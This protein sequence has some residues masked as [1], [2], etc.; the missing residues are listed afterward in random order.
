MASNK[1]SKKK[2]PLHDNILM[3]AASIPLLEDGSGTTATTGKK[4]NSVKNYLW[5]QYRS[6]VRKHHA[7]IDLAD[8]AV[9]RLLFWLPHHNH[10][11]E[12][13]SPPWREVLY[14]ILSV[15]QL[16]MYCSQQDQMENTYGFSLS[17]VDE[18]RISAISLR[19]VMHA[20]HSLMPSIL[21]VAASS[22]AGNLTPQDRRKRQAWARYR[23]EQFKF[24]ARLYLTYRYW[25]QIRQ[26]GEDSSKTRNMQPGIMLNGGIYQPMI[27]SVGLSQEEMLTIRLKRDY[28][29][30]R[31]GLSLS[32]PDGGTSFNDDSSTRL[33]SS[34]R[35][36]LGEFLYMLRPLVWAN[37][38][39]RYS[40]G[41][42]QGSLSRSN[43]APHRGRDSLS[44]AW[45]ITLVM[46]V[47]SLGFLSKER[48]S[49]NTV[50]K[51]EWFR[52]RTKLM[53]YLLRAP[54]WTKATCPALEKTSDIAS[55]IPLLGRIF[56]SYLWDWVLYWKHPFV[57]EEG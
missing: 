9:H 38:E 24:A 21:E 51:E 45:L 17:T 22:S 49:G 28:R 39:A 15:N 8:D 4:P 33:S 43:Q 54:M 23:L 52:R 19:I 34:I 55:H 42:G 53:L 13:M 56:E 50:S 1:S 2:K 30:R 18:P 14:G 10:S 46:D 41:G 29:G 48:D 36:F 11:D 20:L 47:L 6:F 35:L 57:S 40:D 32:P 25:G 27:D 12:D 3:S 5:S 44:K 16:A 31:T 37:A 26:E 7:T